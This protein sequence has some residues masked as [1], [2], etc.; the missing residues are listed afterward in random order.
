MSSD[1][2]ESK[3][4]SIGAAAPRAPQVSGKDRLAAALRDTRGI[5]LKL[6]ESG[7]ELPELVWIAASL[8]PDGVRL[9]DRRLPESNGATDPIVS[10]AHPSG[11]PR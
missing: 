5:G 7:L 4:S 6:P 8:L 3:H 2:P 11:S 10:A 9:I 1:K